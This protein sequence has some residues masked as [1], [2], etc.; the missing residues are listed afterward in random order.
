MYMM[1]MNGN[2][3]EYFAYDLK[4][5]CSEMKSIFS[6]MYNKPNLKQYT[7]KPKLKKLT[8]I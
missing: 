1:V 6:K 2:I 5:F 7:V 3:K 8:V 4:D